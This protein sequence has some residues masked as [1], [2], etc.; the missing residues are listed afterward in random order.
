MR[1]VGRAGAV[2]VPIRT[3]HG[4]YCL[5]AAASHVTSIPPMTTSDATTA[6]GLSRRE[7]LKGLGGAAVATAVVG[8]R[9]VT[10]PTRAYAASRPNV[11]LVTGDDLGPYLGCYGDR[12]ART[13]EIDKLAADPDCVQ[14]ERA[15]VTQ[16]SCSP[17]RSSMLT[18]LYPHQNGQ[19]GLAS[20][21]GWRMR[22][23]VRTLPQM[24]QGAGYRTGIIGKLHINPPEAF[25]WDLNGKVRDYDKRDVARDAEVA[26]DFFSNG[27]A[28]FFLMLNYLDPHEEFVEQVKGL[29]ADPHPPGS[30][31]SLPFQQVDTATVMEE[32]RGYRN[33][34]SRLD[35]GIGKLMAALSQTGKLDNTLLIFL[36]DNG[37]PFARAK[38]TCYEAGVRTPLLV[39]FPRRARPVQV[40]TRKLVSAIDLVP[41]ILDATGAA[42]PGGLPG[43]SLLPLI[44]PTAGQDLPWRRTLVTEYHAHEHGKPSYPR[45]AIRDDRFKCIV[46][47]N[48]PGDPPY[49]K[50]TAYPDSQRGRYRDT[51][52]GRA[53]ALAVD[54][55]RKEL[56]DL[57]SDPHEFVNLAGVPEHAA[58]LED[59]QDKLDDWQVDTEDPLRSRTPR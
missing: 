4:G 21:P 34:V 42:G 18:G 39:R 17:S 24:L 49:G 19:L 2:L 16:A 30:V 12:Q 40:R 52:Q 6:P 9:A 28:P 48:S 43:R 25:P 50:G 15:Y 58:V 1:A 37:P 22:S 23:D 57:D 32:V 51:P 31:P 47:L 54:P 46:N 45:R 7:V 11:V 26:R 8:T 10:R 59:L 36:G 3:D 44:S 27:S 55:P 33:C 14:F 53:H 56:Y 13:P 20:D 41:T 5:S 35:A 29:P 38:L